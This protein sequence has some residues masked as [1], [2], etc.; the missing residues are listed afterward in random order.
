MLKEALESNNVSQVKKLSSQS[1]MVLNAPLDDLGATCLHLAAVM[2][3]LECLE[4]M[5][6]YGDVNVV[7]S[8]GH[9]VLHSAVDHPE[10]LS[11]LLK[12]KNVDVNRLA[13]NRQSLLH[14]MARKF[15][16]VDDEIWALLKKVRFH[17]TNRT[18][19]RAF[20]TSDCILP[21]SMD[22]LNIL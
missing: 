9:T 7:D 4:I 16:P 5:L 18:S 20:S 10:V 3:N 14:I 1:P 8:V 21:R 13:F 22:R 19:K 15:S 11:M 2:G 12:R 6:K 17:Y